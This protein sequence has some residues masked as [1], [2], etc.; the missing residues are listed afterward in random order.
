MDRLLQTFAALY[1]V[2]MAIRCI[3]TYLSNIK[4]DFALLRIF[5]TLLGRRTMCIVSKSDHT[6]YLTAP[7]THLCT[8]GFVVRLLIGILL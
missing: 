7:P 8:A 2:F 3:L 4:Q 1:S 5:I 6:F